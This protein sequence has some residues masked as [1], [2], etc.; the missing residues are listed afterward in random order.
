MIVV[1]TLV[2]YGVIN[3]I[4]FRMS[5]YD[6]VHT[7]AFFNITSIFALMMIFIL[8]RTVE[9]LLGSESRVPRNEIYDKEISDSEY[10]SQY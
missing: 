5:G 1:A 3:A 10:T 6:Y 4:L 7:E 9:I 2:L 8:P